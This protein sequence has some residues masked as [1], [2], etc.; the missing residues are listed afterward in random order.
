MDFIISCFKKQLVLYAVAKDVHW[1]Q[2]SKQNVR[3]KKTIFIADKSIKYNF[4][5]QWALKKTV[6]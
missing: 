2:D 6:H 5:I 1:T 4:K 3:K